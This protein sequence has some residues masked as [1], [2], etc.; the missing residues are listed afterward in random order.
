MPSLLQLVYYVPPEIRTPLYLFSTKLNNRIPLLPL[1]FLPL[2]PTSP[3]DRYDPEPRSRSTV[4][5][6]TNSK[7]DPDP[8]GPLDE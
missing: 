8:H 2:S 6:G 7:Y 5:S 1:T 3:G 4:G